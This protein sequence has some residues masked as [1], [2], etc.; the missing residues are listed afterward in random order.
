MASKNKK[1]YVYTLKM[2]VADNSNTRLVITYAKKTLAE[3]HLKC[4]VWECWYEQFSEDKDDTNYKIRPAYPEEVT[5]ADVKEFQQISI[6]GGGDIESFEIERQEVLTAVDY[7]FLRDIPKFTIDSK[8]W[9]EIEPSKEDGLFDVTVKAIDVEAMAVQL[10]TLLRMTHHIRYTNDQLDILDVL[11]DIIEKCRKEYDLVD[12]FSD[13]PDQL[14]NVGAIS[15]NPDGPHSANVRL[16]SV[17]MVVLNGALQKI[18]QSLPDPSN[19]PVIRLLRNV[20][21][22]WN[23]GD[24]SDL[25]DD[26]VE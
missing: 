11:Q 2:D 4:Y 21:D 24:F 25:D 19:D 18:E 22:K 16:D 10:R 9:C 12:S 23:K 13:S 14:G 5:M 6:D 1:D 8:D 17:N 26:S 7:K 15:N 20:L 3:M